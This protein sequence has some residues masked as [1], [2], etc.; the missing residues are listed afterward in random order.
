LSVRWSV[1]RWCEKEM[2]CEHRSFLP[3]FKKKKI[4]RLKQK[5][6]DLLSLKRLMMRSC[7]KEMSCQ[8]RPFLPFSR[9]RFFNWKKDWSTFCQSENQSHESLAGRWTANELMGRSSRLCWGSGSVACMLADDEPSFDERTW[10]MCFAKSPIFFVC[11]FPIDNWQ[12]FQNRLKK[13][14]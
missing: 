1:L 12:A 14:K 11:R 3:L 2:R 13:S 8:H 5:I 10:P 4:P 7:L 9:R 6:N